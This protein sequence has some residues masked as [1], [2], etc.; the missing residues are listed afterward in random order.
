[1]SGVIKTGATLSSLAI[2]NDPPLV[3]PVPGD[4]RWRPRRYG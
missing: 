2:L 4:A 1:M 3:E